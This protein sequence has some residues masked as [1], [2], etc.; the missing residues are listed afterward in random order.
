MQ[1]FPAIEG[2]RA[3]FNPLATVPAG[4]GQLTA[5]VNGCIFGRFG[6]ADPNSG[7]VSNSFAPGQTIGFVLPQWFRFARNGWNLAYWEACA[8]VL[9]QGMSVVLA[10][11]GDFWARFCGG[12]QAG[13]KV[14]ASTSDGSARTGVYGPEWTADSTVTA[15]SIVYSAD[16]GGFVATHWTVL[17]STPPG[18]LALI[19]SYQPPF[20]S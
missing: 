19:S 4:N 12:A 3:N 1:S 8:L 9:R 7:Q 16:G 15:D 11:A 18:G 17:T 20:S 10:A 13:Q 5:G 14:W 2:S 6:F